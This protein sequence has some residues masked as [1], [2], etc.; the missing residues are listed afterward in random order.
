[1][2]NKR[3]A[4]RK[5]LS[6][7]ASELNNAFKGNFELGDINIKEPYEMTETQLD[8][9]YQLNAPKTN[10]VFV[11]GP[12]G[13]MKTFLGVYSG[14]C[15]LQNTNNNIRNLIYI[16]SAVESS[17]TSL[18]A[19]PGEIEDKFSPYSI[20]L[21]EKLR[22]IIPANEVD[23]LFLNKHVEAIPI[24]F[25]RG[26]TFK[27]AIVIVDEAQNMNKSELTTILTRIGSNCKYYVCGDTFQSD[28]RDSGFEYIKNAFDTEHSEKNNIFTHDFD[29][30][31]ISR[32][33]ILQ[34]VTEVLQSK[35]EKQRERKEHKL[36]TE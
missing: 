16:R 3:T 35:A 9:L 10:M 13:S 22:E 32:S 1:M 27:N 5:A 18:G 25:V 29:V 20:P 6:A 26:R 8:C 19:I 11:D 36:I 23:M 7:E 17:S 14:I 31:D 21:K 2:S 4:R 33:K 30:S 24:N 12:A 15:H 34:H 28:I